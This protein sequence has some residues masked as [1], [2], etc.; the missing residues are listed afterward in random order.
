MPRIARTVRTAA[1]LLALA[2]VALFAEGPTTIRNIAN[3]RIKETDRLHAL[4]TELRRLGAGAHAGEDS[5]RIE[6]RA[7]RGATVETYDEFKQVLE[8]KGGFIRMHWDG[9]EETEKRIKDETKA[10]IRLIPMEGYEEEGV[11]PV[12]GQPSKGYVVFARAY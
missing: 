2:V 4:E 10:T 9:T 7:L 5:L 8:E 1:L 11:D 12:S 3:L 6:P